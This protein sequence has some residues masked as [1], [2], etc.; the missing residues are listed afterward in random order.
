MSLEPDAIQQI[1]T[2]STDNLP[3]PLQSEETWIAYSFHRKYQTLAAQSVL[4]YECIA[5]VLWH[6][7]D[8]LKTL[9]NS[10]VF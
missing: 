8:K 9:R 3:Q 5:R 6:I 10:N 2:K 7:S 1:Y 4:S